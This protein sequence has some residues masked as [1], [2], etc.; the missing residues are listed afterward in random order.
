MIKLQLCEFIICIWIDKSCN[1]LLKFSL[2]CGKIFERHSEN[3]SESKA[4]IS[5]ELRTKIDKNQQQKDYCCNNVL[6]IVT[7]MS[8]IR[9]FLF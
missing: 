1:K 9:Q 5:Y 2:F 6:N 3:E 7:D 8:L 4:R